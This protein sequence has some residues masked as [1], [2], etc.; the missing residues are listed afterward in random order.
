MF[1]RRRGACSWTGMHPGHGYIPENRQ[2][3][4]FDKGRCRLPAGRSSLP[5]L[6]KQQGSVIGGFWQVGI[7]AGGQHR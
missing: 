7:G 6:F 4:G 3:K 5:V 1:A 2:A